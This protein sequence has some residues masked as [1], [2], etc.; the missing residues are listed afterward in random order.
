MEFSL[1][2]VFFGYN[3]ELVSC[4]DCLKFQA[5]RDLGILKR[6]G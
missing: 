3:G 5:V 1:G 4:S 6:P 2:L